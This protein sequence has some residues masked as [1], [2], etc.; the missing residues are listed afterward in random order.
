MEGKAVMK[1]ENLKTTL[2]SAKQEA[3]GDKEKVHQMLNAVT[4]ELC[5]AKNML[6]KVPGQ[7]EVCFVRYYIKGL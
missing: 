2:D 6:D 4:P 3:R 1:A 7:Q 5:T